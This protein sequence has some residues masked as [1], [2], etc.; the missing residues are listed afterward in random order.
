MTQTNIKKDMQKLIDIRGVIEKSG[1]NYSD[2]ATELFPL[3]AYPRLALNRVAD[4]K[5]GAHLD[6]EQISKL[7]SL[8]GLNISELFDE[9]EWS[10]K[11]EGD[12]VTFSTK[13][14]RAELDLKT[15]KTKIYH[16]NSLFHSE[17]IH[18]L[19]VPLSEYLESLNKI[20]LNHK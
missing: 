4:R 3:N 18:S 15:N 9:T 8:L 11:I 17:I 7:A 1:L 14:Y 5:N 13:D 10:S 16:L 19:T 12:K 2:V 20:I 6:E